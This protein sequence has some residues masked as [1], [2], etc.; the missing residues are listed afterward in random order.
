[1]KGNVETT[2]P[3]RLLELEGMRGVAA[4][5]VVVYHA[6]LFFYPGIYGGA[7]AYLGNAA[8]HM[9][10]EDNLFANPLTVLF[11][12]TAA[13]AIFFVLSGFVLSVGYFQTG[14]IEIIQKHAT[15]RY[16]RLMLPALG[17]ILLTWVIMSVGLHAAKVSALDITHSAWLERQWNITPSLTEGIW[18]GLVGMFQGAIGYNNVLWTMKLE[19]IGSFI[20]F[21]VVALV[22]KLPLRWIV[23]V[24]LCIALQ[25]SWY[26]GFVLGMILA[27]AYVHKK[28]PFTIGNQGLLLVAFVMGIFFLGYSSVQNNITL[29][30]TMYAAS[31]L[32]WLSDAG[33]KKFYLTIGSAMILVA[34]MMI[35]RLKRLFSYKWISM[36]GTYTFAL[37]LT[38]Y[39]V[40]FTVCAG[41][42]VWLYPLVGYHYAALTAFVCSVP[43]FIGVSYV[44][45]KYVDAPSIRLASAFSRWFLRR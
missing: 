41:V 45:E 25:N 18:Q 42:F 13:V 28:F 24:V 40:L 11:H 12:G 2:R 37:Y 22:G 44:F 7:T 27:D 38:H 36:L 33:N 34:V 19:F 3:S 4:I 32:P 30:P 15:K 29:Q 31:A 23:Y 1:M 21:G 20:V 8:Q 17:S 39:A 14:T 35:P 26:L 43:F 10:Y 6:I 16:L 9:R 5:V